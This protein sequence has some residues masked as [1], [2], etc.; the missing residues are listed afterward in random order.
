[1][2]RN[3]FKILAVS[4]IAAVTLGICGSSFAAISGGTSTGNRYRA[5][6]HR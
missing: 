4:A 1:M 6:L 2:K 5:D 3:T